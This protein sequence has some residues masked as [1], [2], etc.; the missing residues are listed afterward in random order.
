MTI[1]CIA[2]DDEPLALELVEGYINKIPFLRLVGTFDNSG[3]ALEVINN[4]PID[5]IYSDINMP[6]INGLQLVKVL[7]NGPKVIFTTAY[8]S[9][10]VQGFELDAVDYLLKPFSFERFLIATEKALKRM[11]KNRPP[12]RDASNDFI[13]IKTEHNMVKVMLDAIYFIEGYKDYLK[14][15]TDQKNPIL[16]L[17]SMKSM[18]KILEHKGFIRI[19]RS[20]IISISKIHSVR[21]GKIRI[22]ETSLPI[23]D[24]YKENFHAQVLDGKI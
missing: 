13:F 2:I 16:T 24:N 3:E 5:L 17:K 12:V 4:E 1:N 9:F 15:H 10:A 11:G 14:I 20:Y 22:K 21:N 6:D 23:G 18:E 19:H 7:E 8:D